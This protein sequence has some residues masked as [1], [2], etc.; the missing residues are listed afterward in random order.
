M[1]LASARALIWA[2]VM[3]ILF[4]CVRLHLCFWLGFVLSS[5]LYR[6]N[7]FCIFFSF[8]GLEICI[9]FLDDHFWLLVFAFLLQGWVIFFI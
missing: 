4:C 7:N 9:F 3:G 5:M 2:F 8:F 1:E 6:V